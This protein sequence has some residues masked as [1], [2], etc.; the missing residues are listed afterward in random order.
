MLFSKTSNTILGKVQ[1]GIGAQRTWSTLS[2]WQP[3]KRTPQNH[4]DTVCY[5]CDRPST[6]IHAD[7]SISVLDNLGTEWSPHRKYNLFNVSWRIC[8]F[9]PNW[10]LLVFGH[11]LS[12]CVLL[13]WWLFL[14][15]VVSQVPVIAVLIGF[16]W[17]ENK[18]GDWGGKSKAGHFLPFLH[19][20]FSILIEPSP[21]SLHTLPQGLWWCFSGLS[22]SLEQPAM[23]FVHRE[24]VPHI[25]RG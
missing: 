19:P 2:T 3:L 9:S 14:Q 15:V 24:Q 17:Q 21:N 5:H 23:V 18:A 4:E 25:R 8:E 13:F 12:V 16:D 22:A 7:P 6:C 10:L 11:W 1:V 20:L